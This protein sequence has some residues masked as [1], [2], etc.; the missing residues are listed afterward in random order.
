MFHVSFSQ[1]RQLFE[2]LITLVNVP[3]SMERSAILDAI[4][5]SLTTALRNLEIQPIMTQ[6]DLDRYGITIIVIDIY[7]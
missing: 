3:S 5:S 7:Y 6:I 2:L 1:Q 4:E